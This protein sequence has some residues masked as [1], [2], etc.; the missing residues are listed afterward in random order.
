LRGLTLRGLPG[1]LRPHH[2]KRIHRRLASILQPRA[3]P[4]NE[5]EEQHQ[6]NFPW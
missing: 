1:K 4:R 6:G 2:G 5:C 3:K